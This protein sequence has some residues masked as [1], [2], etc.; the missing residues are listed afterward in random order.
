[1][2][3]PNLRTLVVHDRPS[4]D[5]VFDASQMDLLLSRLT[6]PGLE[7]LSLELNLLP[8]RHLHWTALDA[9]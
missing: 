7:R 5:I 2:R 3:S 1:M 8:Y 6:A 4:D 9:L